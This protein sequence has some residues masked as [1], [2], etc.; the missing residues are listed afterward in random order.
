MIR[1]RHFMPLVI[2]FLCS[3]LPEAIHAQEITIQNEGSAPI[4]LSAS[5]ISTLP[6]QKVQVSDHG[7]QVAFEGVQLSLILGKAGVILGDTL[8]GGRMASC[9]LVEAKDGYRV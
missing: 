8:R 5:Q 9:L 1:L 6:H 3:P 4:K 7:K 2:V